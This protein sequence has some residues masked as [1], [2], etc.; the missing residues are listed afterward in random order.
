MVAYRS[1]GSQRAPVAMREAYLRPRPD[2]PV[3]AAKARTRSGWAVAGQPFPRRVYDHTCAIPLVGKSHP[4][5]AEVWLGEFGGTVVCVMPSDVEDQRVNRHVGADPVRAE[6][7]E[8]E[9]AT[10][11]HV[12]R[13][14][15]SYGS[16]AS[17]PMPRGA[18]R[19]S[20]R[21]APLPFEQPFPDGS[22]DGVFPRFE[23]LREARSW[24]LA[25]APARCR[26]PP[27]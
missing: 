21:G 20:A 27:R 17:I 18:V 24:L 7:V 14:A 15:G 19:R 11:A 23:Y 8:D 3:A 6:L 9:R 1:F 16:P 2:D 12:D 26:R 4:E 5:S 10:L 25:I 13:V 22:D